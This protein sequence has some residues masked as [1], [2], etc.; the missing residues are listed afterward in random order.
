MGLS[1]GGFIRLHDSIAGGAETAPLNL[2]SVP[3]EF[4]YCFSLVPKDSPGFKLPTKH[5][6]MGEENDFSC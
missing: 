1:P 5:H 6:D 4:K 2:R 3:T